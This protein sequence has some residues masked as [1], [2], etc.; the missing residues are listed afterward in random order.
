[1][2][3]LDYTGMWSCTSGPV[4]PAPPT[5]IA[6]GYRADLNAWYAAQRRAR[7]RWEAWIANDD[8]EILRHSQ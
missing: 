3:I 8:E 7:E 2:D 4:P 5:I 6:G 1:M